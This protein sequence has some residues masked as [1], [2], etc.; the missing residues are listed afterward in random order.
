M[1]EGE[2]S[3]NHG[4]KKTLRMSNGLWL[5]VLM[6]YAL[7][8][9]NIASQGTVGTLR[10]SIADEVSG[11]PISARVELLDQEGRAYVPLKE[12]TLPVGGNCE[13]VEVPWNGTFEK[14]VAQEDRK[15]INPY[16]GT[17]QFYSAGN[18]KILLPPGPY[19]LKVYKGIEYTVWTGTI[20]IQ[21]DK[22]TEHH[23][24]LSRWIN[25]PK[26]GWYSA[27]DH[28]HIARPRKD[29]NPALSKW[30]QA[31]DLHVA[32][33]LQWGNTQ[34]FQNAD[35]FAHGPSGVY[36]EGD[37]LLSSGQENPRT[38]FLGHTIILGTHSP[39]NFPAAYIIYG[40]FWEE[41]RR[42]GALTGYAHFGKGF[43]ALSG[44]SID[45][46][47]NL[48][49]FL[50]VLQGDRLDTDVWYDILNTG[51]RMTPTAG[52]DY[53]CGLTLP[54][55]DRFYTEVRGRLTY[56]AWLEGIRRG[57]T[58]VTN[59]PILEFSVN[60]TGIGGEV[61]LKESEPVT[62]EAR[63]LINPARDDVER[64]E[65]IA[66]GQL[67]RSFSRPEGSAEIRG[68]FRQELGESSWLA[69]RASGS[70]LGEVLHPSTGLPHPSLAH[71]APIYVRVEAAPGISAHPR[72]R[73][74]RKAWV[75]RLE[76]LRVVLADDQKIEDLAREAIYE[77]GVKADY[78]R[79]NRSS[80]LKAIESA[81]EYFNS[82][83]SAKHLGG[84]G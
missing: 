64:L 60:G 78:I 51:F 5:L 54:G 17:A 47:T 19:R 6:S 38:H 62:V 68:R 9:S 31:E 24:R 29:L 15:I 66:N 73:A 69:V 40:L 37:Y 18:S 72:A 82:N 34:R 7:W 48:L 76:H 77:D 50:E 70:K 41:A 71:S 26:Q 58:F 20:D 2:H 11:Q 30:M 84:D 35:Q 49:S 36:R 13:D 28:L 52:T 67:L 32:N 65:V 75:A 63:A 83:D 55:R 8:R 16:T 53:P 21:V 22:R 45:L 44:L 81:M 59:G 33:L 1:I 14:A 23:V 46:S 10:L 80:L 56:D 42:Q 39:I 12:D 79:R 74:L 57:R 43:G 4:L 3:G 25:L 61:I 27:D